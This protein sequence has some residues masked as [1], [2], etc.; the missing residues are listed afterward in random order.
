VASPALE[1]PTVTTAVMGTPAYMAPERLVGGDFDSRADVYS[2]GVMAYEMLTGEKPFGGDSWAATAA[3][4]AQA[5]PS[6][7][8]RNAN[9]PAGIGAIVERALARDAR[10]RPSA[11]EFGR[12][13]VSAAAA[14]SS[15]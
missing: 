15:P 1:L 6:P 5:A 11:D 12:A 14:R 8:A 7:C 9:I 13:F 2:L 4:V 10:K 3:H